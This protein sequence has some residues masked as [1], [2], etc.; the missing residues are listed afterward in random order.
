MLIKRNKEQKWCKQK[1]IN[2]NKQVHDVLSG[3]ENSLIVKNSRRSSQNKKRSPM[4]T[5]DDLQEEHNIIDKLKID[6]SNDITDLNKNDFSESIN[7]ATQK[8]N[9]STNKLIQR[10]NIECYSGEYNQNVN[11]KTISN[12]FLTLSKMDTWQQ[13]DE[14]NTLINIDQTIRQETDELRRSDH[15]QSHLPN[16]YQVKSL[17]DKLGNTRPYCKSHLNYDVDEGNLCGLHKPNP[18]PKEVISDYHPESKKGITVHSLM[19]I[20]GL[21]ES[22]SEGEVPGLLI[23]E[24][25]SKPAY[26]AERFETGINVFHLT[27]F[28]CDICGCTLH[29]G[30]WNKRD[31]NFYCNPCHRKLTLQ[32]FRH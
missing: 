29:R 13:L 21:F 3:N 5:D 2:F 28:K 1:D 8:I 14:F 26:L 27:C 23:C 9:S 10:K 32:T 16:Q 12:E 30:T 25:C 11:V 7:D 24:A 19:S 17:D 20:I 4:Q 31:S 18:V 15:F 6:P 22:I